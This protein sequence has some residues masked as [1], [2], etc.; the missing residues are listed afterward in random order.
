MSA[1]VRFECPVCGQPSGGEFIASAV[2]V[3]RHNDR[4]RLRPRHPAVMVA[5]NPLPLT[6]AKENA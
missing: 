5:V 6:N 1:L 3:C 4:A 2:I